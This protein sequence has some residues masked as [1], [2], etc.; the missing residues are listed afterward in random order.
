MRAGPGRREGGMNRWRDPA[1]R[2][3]IYVAIAV[4]AVVAA[5]LLLR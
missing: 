4:L 2:T 5:T 3:L 1:W